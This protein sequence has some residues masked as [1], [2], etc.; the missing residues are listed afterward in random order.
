V[1]TERDDP[2]EALEVLRDGAQDYLDLSS[3]SPRRIAR[4]IRHAISSAVGLV[5]AP[6]DRGQGMH[7]LGSGC[8]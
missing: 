7:T 6:N 5:A 8:R 3:E 2:D 1:L 4:C